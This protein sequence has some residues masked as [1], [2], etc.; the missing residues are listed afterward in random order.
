[1]IKRMGA[2]LL[3]ILML[4]LPLAALAETLYVNTPNGGSVNLREGPALDDAILTTVPY[5]APVEVLE[6]LLGGSAV[7][8]SYNGYFGYIQ[9]RYLT[10][11]QPAPN[12]D[13][14][15]TFVPAPTYRPVP[16]PTQTP[17]GGGTSLERQL[18]QMYAGFRTSSYEAIVVPSTPS[19]FVNLRWAP[20]KSAP[21]RAQYWANDILEVLND[22][23]TWAEVHDPRTNTYGYIM[24][25]FLKPNGLG[26]LNAGSDS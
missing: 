5:G 8:V 3:T 17:S 26:I 9:I 19:N 10:E 1:M 24:S 14:W 20:S 18:A 13:P 11:Y 6:W 21:V 22:N 15:P 25:G 2:T 12:P 16:A 4:A 7:N 23:G